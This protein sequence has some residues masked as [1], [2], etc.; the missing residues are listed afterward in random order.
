MASGIRTS[1][2]PDNETHYSTKKPSSDTINI[3]LINKYEFCVAVVKLFEIF[4]YLTRK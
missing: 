1:D 2:I 3:M 4:M